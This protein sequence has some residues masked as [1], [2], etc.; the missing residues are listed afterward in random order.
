MV[1]RASSASVTEG[2]GGPQN[3][4]SRGVPGGPGRELSPG[5]ALCA[6]ASDDTATELTYLFPA[7]GPSLVAGS[8]K[9]TVLLMSPA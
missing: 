5:V 6:L 2:T 7:P 8:F 9:T 3:A 4:C 1:A